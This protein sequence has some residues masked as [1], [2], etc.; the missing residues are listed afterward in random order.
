MTSTLPIAKT[1]LTLADLNQRFSL[2]LSPDSLFFP[3]WQQNLPP[4]T[5]S[6]TAA[7]ARWHQRFATH[8]E[9][10]T[11]AE[12]AVDKLLISPLL[13]LVGFFE[14]EYRIQTEAAVQYE[15]EEEDETLRG[16]IDTLIV[17]DQFW[18]LVVEAKRTIMVSLAVPQALAYMMCTPHLER[19]AYG[20]VSNGDEFI[21][22][23]LHAAPQP[24]Y[25]A[26]KL[27][28]LF[29]PPNNQALIEVFQVL[30]QVKLVT[31]TASIRL[32]AE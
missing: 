29:F 26:S 11:I 4:L 1:I 17:Q 3:E 15:L 32:S 27:Y 19:P 22:L 2:R 31:S 12:G 9:R 28:S 7:I 20:M 16:R 13:D 14:P 5:A 25:S 10:G 21:F 6:E 8:R 23:K 30:K 24:E 18:V